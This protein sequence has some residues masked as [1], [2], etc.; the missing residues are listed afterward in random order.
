MPTRG[1]GLLIAFIAGFL[2]AA[3]LLALPLLTIRDRVIELDDAHAALQRTLNESAAEHLLEA[4]HAIQAWNRTHEATLQNA[5]THV[6]TASRLVALTPNRPHD[7]PTLTETLHEAS[8]ALDHATALDACALFPPTSTAQNATAK[9]GEALGTLSQQ[10]S[11]TQPPTPGPAHQA[12][13]EAQ[14]ALQHLAT[15][16]A[17]IRG[18]TLQAD[19]AAIRVSVETPLPNDGCLPTVK[20]TV[21]TTPNGAC[22]TTNGQDAGFARQGQTAFTVPVPQP[23]PPIAA[24]TVSL[25]S[26]AGQTTTQDSADLK[27]PIDP[28][29][30]TATGIAKGTTS[31]ITDPR[32]LVIDTQQAWET[33][34]SEHVDDQDAP[35]VDFETRTVLAVFSGEGQSACRDASITGLWLDAEGSLRVHVRFAEL[36]ATGCPQG[37]VAPFHIVEIP[38]I[39]GEIRFV[40][41]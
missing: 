10:L 31:N 7:S 19:Q 38:H 12:A 17:T 16:H 34:W 27:V 40:P 3:L 5:T 39:P 6:H 30:M 22:E 25:T 13:T 18:L 35:S 9:L 33:A 1:R 15:G 26:T 2:G 32:T 28:W 11:S 4:H 37:T 36:D 41:T 21:C 8:N 24:V 14:D 23:A 20:A 29:P